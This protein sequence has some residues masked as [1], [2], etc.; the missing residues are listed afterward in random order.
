MT[1][2]YSCNMCGKVSAIEEKM[3]KVTFQKGPATH[4]FHFCRKCN[5]IFLR[6][7]EGLIK[8]EKKGGEKIGSD[9]TK[10]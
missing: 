1:I 7:F 10:D 8:S 4:K 6:M 5:M 3:M 2:L 9:S